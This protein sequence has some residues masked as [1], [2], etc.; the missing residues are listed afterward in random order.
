MVRTYVIQDHA[1]FLR[2]VSAFSRTLLTRYDVNAV[3]EELSTRLVDA[4]GLV[5]CG[6]AL[7]SQGRLQ[8][9]SAFPS[10]IAELENVQLEAGR[11]PSA[12]A[13]G[14]GE[15]VAVADVGTEADRWPEYCAA[16]K[17]TGMVAVAGIP[18]RVNG[19]A[20]GAFTLYSDGLREWSDVDLAGAHVLGDMATGYVVNATQL[21]QQEQ[22]N[23]HLQRALDSRVLIEQAKGIVAA[24]T[25]VSV[26]QA[27]EVIRRH[28]RNHNVTLRTVADSI[29]NVGMTI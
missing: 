3:L 8:P 9:A 4:L 6:V 11:G 25:G 18:M 14:S 22:L 20:I 26:D 29:V 13:F 17:P 15:V 21:H 27:F 24:S 5:A 7:E 10:S 19:S 16:A 12:L 23:G 1:L 2:T 28:A